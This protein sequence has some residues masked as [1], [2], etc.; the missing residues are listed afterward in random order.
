[1]QQKE[2]ETRITAAAE[3]AAPEKYPTQT[4]IR[5][6]GF[7]RPPDLNFLLFSMNSRF[8]SIKSWS[9]YRFTPSDKT[10]NKI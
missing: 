1:L 7:S 6:S 2:R 9:I 5:K 10:R 4:I 3:E 8:R